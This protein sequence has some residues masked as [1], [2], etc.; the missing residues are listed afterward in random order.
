M[1]AGKTIHTCFL[2]KRGKIVNAVSVTPIEDNRRGPLSISRGVLI[3]VVI[4]LGMWA[5]IF[6]LIHVIKSHLL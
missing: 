3:S 4:G 1:I 6:A 5:G 2:S